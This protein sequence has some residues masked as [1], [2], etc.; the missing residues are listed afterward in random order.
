MA[1][2]WPWNTEGF[3]LANL[4][5]V[6]LTG[7]EEGQTL[8]LS[9]GTFVPGTPSGTGTPGQD[10]RDI[11]L[12]RGLTH[13]QWRYVG[14]TVWNDL[15]P[16]SELKGADGLPGENGLNGYTPIKGIDYFDGAPGP[17]GDKGDSGGIFSG[18]AKITV[19]TAEPTLPEIGDLWI[20]TN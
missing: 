19:G 13:V 10:G 18:L 20:D 8:I 17:K 9:N 11:E 2:E 3:K 5:D 7:L 6:D 15:V 1:N 14:E 12:Q 4:A 16:L